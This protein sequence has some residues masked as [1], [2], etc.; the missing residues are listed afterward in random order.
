MFII[1]FIFVGV[2]EN[3]GFLAIV[4]IPLFSSLFSLIIIP[5]FVDFLPTIMYGTAVF[6]EML[7]INENEAAD[8]GFILSEEDYEEEE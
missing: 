3:V 7:N 6:Y 8:I 1:I 4:F 5:F 2:V